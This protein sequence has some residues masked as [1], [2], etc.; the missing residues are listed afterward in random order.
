MKTNNN[1][2][3]ML[4]S[5]GKGGKRSS[6][7]AIT[8]AIIEELTSAPAPVVSAP[9]PAPVVS[10]PAPATLQMGVPNLR[11]SRV[12]LRMDQIVSYRIANNQRKDTP[13]KYYVQGG[14]DRVDPLNSARSRFE[15]AIEIP[16]TDLYQAKTKLAELRAG[17][18]APT[19]EIARIA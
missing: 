3:L 1:N 5:K 2:K 16:Y 12:T 11:S 4:T 10:A 9:A 8:S 6:N 14:M 17:L 19:Q 7:S 13:A 18:T 15:V